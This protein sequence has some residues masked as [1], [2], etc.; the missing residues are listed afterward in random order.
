MAIKKSTKFFLL[1]TIV[2]VVLS[3]VTVF[4]SLLKEV[5]V[6]DIVTFYATA[7]GAG[8]SVAALVVSMIKPK[9]HIM[10]N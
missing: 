7:F 10:N 6:V 2:N 9:Q 1:T 3:T 8:A 4:S 5:R